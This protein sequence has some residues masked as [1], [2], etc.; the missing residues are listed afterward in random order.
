M[1]NQAQFLTLGLPNNPPI[2]IPAEPAVVGPHRNSDPNIHLTVLPAINTLEEDPKLD[3]IM[4]PSTSLNKVEVMDKWRRM[5]G[6]NPIALA[7]Q[8]KRA[9]NNMQMGSKSIYL[10]NLE[11]MD[12]SKGLEWMVK[13]IHG[14]V[15]NRANVKHQNEWR[16]ALIMSTVMTQ[17]YNDLVRRRATAPT[18]ITMISRGNKSLKS[19]PV[20]NAWAMIQWM[21]YWDG[22]AHRRLANLIGVDVGARPDQLNK[23][24]LLYK[25]YMK[26]ETLKNKLLSEGEA[27][28]I[29]GGNPRI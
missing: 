1:I 9:I 3:E 2:V 14:M 26:F 6:E 29:R 20:L 19:V 27:L 15:Q 13:S 8:A 21:G 11:P 23:T 18:P 12:Y 16:T 10:G 5:T 25:D 24:S 22:V 28:M 4:L 17:L 7:I